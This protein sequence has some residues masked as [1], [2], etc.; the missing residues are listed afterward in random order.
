MPPARPRINCSSRHQVNNNHNLN[1]AIVS[2]IA[3]Y[4]AVGKVP[5]TRIELYK[6]LLRTGKE[7]VQISFADF[8]KYLD[9]NTKGL[10]QYV[11]HYRGFYF[12]K[13]NPQGYARRIHAG[14]TGVKKWRIARNMAKII[15]L[16]PSVQMIGLT[17]SLALNNTHA[18][19]DIDV[20]VVA[21][22]GSIW[23]TRM[24]VS[25]AMH[26]CGRRRY[27]VRIADR[28]CLNHYI[29]DDALA[30]Q[31]KH[32]FSA[33]ISATLVPLFDRNGTAYRLLDQNTSLTNLYFPNFFTTP[34]LFHLKT[35]TRKQAAAHSLRSSLVEYMLKTLQI[36]R[37]RRGVFTQGEGS[38]F[39]DKALV[40]HHPRPKNQEAMYLYKKNLKNLFTDYPHLD[41]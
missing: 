15:S 28:I 41:T 3:F 2:T 40:F 19:S 7:Q 37:I 32:L 10:L 17:G 29:T 33:H 12:L 35:V 11:S 24:L 21:K 36:R 4:D 22:A 31:P 8:F 16:F 27:G 23:T 9:Y 26:L 34:R 14:K 20:L 30:L 39:N 1:K 6:H 25:A 5:L 18:K 13:N 38:I